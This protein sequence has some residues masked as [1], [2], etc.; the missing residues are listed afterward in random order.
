MW[1]HPLP[2]KVLLRQYFGPAVTRLRTI[3]FIRTDVGD[4]A[5]RSPLFTVSALPTTRAILN[6]VFYVIFFPE[7]L[8]QHISLHYRAARRAEQD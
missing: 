6:T 1:L 8:P 2:H 4:G 5:V 3:G 7:D